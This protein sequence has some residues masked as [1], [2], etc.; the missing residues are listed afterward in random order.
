MVHSTQLDRAK[1]VAA[2]AKQ[3]LDAYP[4]GESVWVKISAVDGYSKKAKVQGS[5]K[6]VD[7]QSGEDLDPTSEKLLFDLT[8]RGMRSELNERWN[9]AGDSSRRAASDEPSAVTDSCE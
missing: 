1:L 4:K 3:P 2:K 8:S 5:V 9:G 6:Y 7:Q